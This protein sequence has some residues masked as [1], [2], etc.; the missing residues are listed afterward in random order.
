MTQRTAAPAE[1]RSVIGEDESARATP[2]EVDLR[3]EQLSHTKRILDLQIEG[4]RAIYRDALG[5][6]LVNALTLG[7][8]FVSG[9][10]VIAM[11]GLT[12][13]ASAQTSVVLFG[14][15]T[16]GI[17]VSMAYATTAYLGDIADYAR[18]VTD[19]DGEAFQNKAISS[20]VS[21]I[22]R[23]ARAMEAK[24]E[25]LRTALLSMVGGLVVLFLGLGFQFIQLD[26]WAQVLV[27]LNALAVIGYLLIKVMSFDY[28]ESKKDRLL[29]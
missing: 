13:A 27:S 28:L 16:L 23:N 5:I 2:Q 8:L 1:S 22:K 26:S 18:P 20:N 7:G 12:I 4:S 6:F 11:G 14:I 17:F 21:I 29:R 9:V 19:A 24:V 10:L 25:G 3:A 15:G